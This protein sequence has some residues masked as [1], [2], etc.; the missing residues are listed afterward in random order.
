[1]GSM[2]RIAATLL[3]AGAAYNYYRRRRDRNLKGQTALITGSSRGLGFLMAREY[4]RLGCQVVIC[5]TDEDE[6]DTA[7]E[8]L[9]GEG[10]DVLAIVCDVSDESQVHRMVQEVT[11]HF[12]KVDI[13]VNN[14]GIIQVGPAEAHTLKDFEDAMGVMFYGTLLPIREVLPQMMER[15]SGRI[16][17]ITSIGAKLSMPHLLPY[18]CA[19]YA[20]RGLSQGLH[21]ELRRHRISVTTVVP[22]LMRTGSFIN[23]AYKGRRGGEFAWFSLG[24]SLPLISINAT[25][26]ARQ[27]VEAS[28]QRDTEFVVGMPAK[29]AGLFAGLFPGLTADILGGVNMLLPRP[30]EGRNDARTGRAVRKGLRTT[31]TRVL[32]AGT[33]LG[34][35]AGQF[36]NQG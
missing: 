11:G 3:G 16:V 15:R 5:A 10:A 13:L 21:A 25:R 27:I 28:R 32:D 8:R 18:T 12:G 31:T 26:A 33:T 30:D 19:K 7:R 4:A 6:L 36:N 2:T 34:R 14:A 1:M 20:A 9:R 29:F 24:S 23:A 22:G 17:N 35:R